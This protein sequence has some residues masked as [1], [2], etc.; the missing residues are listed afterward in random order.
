VPVRLQPYLKSLNLMVIKAQVTQSRKRVEYREQNGRLYPAFVRLQMGMNITQGGNPTMRYEFTSEM[1]VR[2]LAAAPAPFA[3]SEQHSGSLY[4]R[5][6]KYTRPYWRE[7][8]VVAAT[9]AEE[10]AI[11]ALEKGGGQ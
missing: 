7:G 8:N 1:L 4:K 6:T 3:K 11:K 5:G 9:A 2:G 10:A